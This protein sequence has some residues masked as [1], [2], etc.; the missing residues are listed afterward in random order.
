M[1]NII[2]SINY[3]TLVKNVYPDAKIYSAWDYSNGWCDTL[4]SIDWH[5][6][7]FITA[8]IRYDYMSPKDRPNLWKLAWDKIQRELI[9][10]LSE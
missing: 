3:E 1:V 7:R 2:S 10:K 5:R 8:P 6:S 4:L 9:W